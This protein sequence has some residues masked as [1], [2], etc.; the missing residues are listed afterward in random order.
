MSDCCCMCGAPAV[1]DYSVTDSGCASSECE[2]A[3]SEQWCRDC[4]AELAAGEHHSVMCSHGVK[5]VREDLAWEG[6][7]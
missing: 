7:A 6:A 4:G 5:G 3:W 1:L 2:R